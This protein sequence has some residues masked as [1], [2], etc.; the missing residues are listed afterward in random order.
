[1]TGEDFTEHFFVAVTFPHLDRLVHDIFLIFTEEFLQVRKPRHIKLV[2]P[3]QE[4]ILHHQ[5]ETQ[6]HIIK[7]TA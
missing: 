6:N 1:M 4:I 3:A 5:K 2:D 7:D